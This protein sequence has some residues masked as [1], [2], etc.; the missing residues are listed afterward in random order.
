[1]SW[2]INYT[3]LL[4]CFCDLRQSRE[5]F[6]FVLSKCWC[7]RVNVYQT[8][9]VNLFMISMA[10]PGKLIEFSMEGHQF[11][12]KNSSCA[13]IQTLSNIGIGRVCYW[14]LL[15]N[16]FYQCGVVMK[17]SK[18]PTFANN[19][20]SHPARQLDLATLTSVELCQP[21]G[22]PELG[23]SL[24]CLLHVWESCFNFTYWGG[25][26]PGRALW[27]V[28]FIPNIFDESLEV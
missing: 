11:Q 3:A 22:P 12:A 14:H 15:S 16:H 5:F 6:F 13:S 23:P 24:P 26:R 10:G 21:T 9:N 17:Y 18:F 4:F 8:R 1:M 28:G 25:F 7:H 19:I 20:L 27:K 2:F